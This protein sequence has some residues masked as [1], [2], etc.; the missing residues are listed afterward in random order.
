MGDILTRRTAAGKRYTSR[1][2]QCNVVL[3]SVWNAFP[4][5]VRP[6]RNRDWSRSSFFDHTGTTPSHPICELVFAQTLTGF[7]LV[8]L[9]EKAY[10]LLGDAFRRPLSTNQA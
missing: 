5:I 7:R 1:F 4:W 9:S 2:G 8:M 3:R 10:I 6:A